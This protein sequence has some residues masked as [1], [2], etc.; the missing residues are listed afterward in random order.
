MCDRVRRV[1]RC[2]SL[3]VYRGS[4]SGAIVFLICYFYS[5]LFSIGSFSFDLFSIGSFSFSLLPP[6]PLFYFVNDLIFAVHIYIRAHV[7]TLVFFLSLSLLVLSI[8]STTATATLVNGRRPARLYP[9]ADAQR[10]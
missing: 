4:A 3:I 2:V 1:V 6:D 7:R 5:N 10:R 8:C 9:D